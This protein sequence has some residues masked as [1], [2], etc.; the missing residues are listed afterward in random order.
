MQYVVV[1]C[2]MLQCVAEEHDHDHLF[3]G[4]YQA[5]DKH[6]RGQQYS[7]VQRICHVLHM[8]LVLHMLRVVHVLHT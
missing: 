8:F 2:S 6:S 4:A 7:N 5:G 1:C 3:I